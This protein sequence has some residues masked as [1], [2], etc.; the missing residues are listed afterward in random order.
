LHSLQSL[1]G[2]KIEGQALTTHSTSGSANQK[3]SSA[4]PSSLSQTEQIKD[5]CFG[6]LPEML[7]I[8]RGKQTLYGYPALVD[9]QTHCDI[10]VFDDPEIAR[11]N[12]RQGLRR[13]FALPMKETIK[14]LHKQLPGARDLS[15]LFMNIGSSDELMTQI[16]E[17]ALDRACLT[18][19]L[20]N[21][22]A[23]FK[24]R[25]DAGKPKLALI[26]QEIARHTLASL[27]AF[28]DLQKKMAALK[29]LSS[30]AHADVTNQIQKMI[31]AQFIAETP[32]ESLVHIPRYLKAVLMR[33]EK[34][35]SNPARDAQLQVEWQSIYNPWIKLIQSQ[36][37]YG[38]SVDSRLDDIRWQLEELRVALFAQ[39]LKTPTPMSTKRLQKILESLRK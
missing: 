39:E 26:A 6:E 28:A 10:E 35:R 18:E 12:H 8:K 14:S 5:W 38:G 20:P 17:L 37:V 15:L 11:K 33:I 31:H 27:Q 21:N 1:K 32:Y 29:A 4:T 34:L 2:L 24:E 23:S 22:D 13:L 19:P 3:I 25:L 7:E 36:K 9:H 30:S 16:I